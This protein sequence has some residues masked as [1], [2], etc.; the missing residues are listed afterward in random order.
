MKETDPRLTASPLY[1][2]LPAMPVPPEQPVSA[3]VDQMTLLRE[4]VEREMA[5]LRELIEERTKPKRW[6]SNGG[7]KSG[8]KR[9][10]RAEK[11]YGKKACTLA[12]SIWDKDPKLS[13]PNLA[14]EIRN[15]WPFKT[16]YGQSMLPKLIPLWMKE[17]RLVRPE[18][19]I[20]TK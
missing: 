11:K 20:I 13:Q 16:T 9:R 17:G 1:P 4:A 3:L 12:Q 5:L 19:V 2:S 18:K 7:T 6:R 8:V 10:K 14:T 15:R